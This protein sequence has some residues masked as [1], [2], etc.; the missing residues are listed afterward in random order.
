VGTVTKLG[1]ELF[2]TTT[3]PVGPASPL[4]VTVPVTTVDDP[5]TTDDG[6]TVRPVKVAG[7]TVSQAVWVTPAR[8]PL[9]EIATF[10]AT[11]DVET[12]KLTLVAPPGIVTDAGT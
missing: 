4:S 9:I 7:A 12:E 11:P 3:F 5:P 10:D 1:L 6:E 8:V 2:R